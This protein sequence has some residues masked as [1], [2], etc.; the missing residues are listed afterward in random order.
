[1]AWKDSLLDCSFRG[2][3]FDVIDVDDSLAKAAAIFEFPY[4]DGGEVEDL[5]AHPERF[6]L[7]AI[8]F[9]D[10]YKARLTKFLDAVNRRG[11]GELV[12]PVWGS[13]P[14]VVALGAQVRHAAPE[15]DAATVRVEFVVSSAE[16]PF[17]GGSTAS[18]KAGAVVGHGDR[19]ASSALSRMADALRALRAASPLASLTALRASMNEPLFAAL[20]QSQGIVLSGLDVLAYPLAW[21]ADIAALADGFIGLADIPGNKLSGMAG[22]ASLLSVFERGANGSAPIAPG[23]TPSERQAQNSVNAYLAV[24]AVT[25]QAAGVAQLL[26]AEAQT[27]TLSPPEIESAA[28]AT[29]TQ[30]DAAIETVRAVYPLEQAREMAEPLKDQ[31]LAVQEAARAVIEARP[32]LVER[33]VDLPGNLR[34]LAHAWYGDHDRAVEM[35]RLNPALRL[36]NALRPG[37]TL[38][39]YAI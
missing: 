34:L 1:M 28:N 27:P 7:N 21:G 16:R 22:L 14:L 23:V 38:H 10:D 18:Q 15:P 35:A 2:V 17:F 20:A 6:T 4:Q 13:M 26:A 12:H 5:G 9:G 11:A 29:R 25:A 39:A 32:P 3:V 30:I 33:R 19:A 36:P 37:D 24:S 31:A 8:F